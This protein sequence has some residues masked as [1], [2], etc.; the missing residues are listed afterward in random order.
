MNFVIRIDRIPLFWRGK[1]IA[2]IE[3][4][5]QAWAPLTHSMPNQKLLA[6]RLD[7]ILNWKYYRHCSL[8][9]KKV[10]SKQV[11]FGIGEHRTVTKYIREIKEVCNTHAYTHS[12]IIASNV[13]TAEGWRVPVA[14]RKKG[15]QSA[16]KK[17]R[18]LKWPFSSKLVFFIVVSIISARLI[19][20]LSN[21]RLHLICKGSCTLVVV[22]LRAFFFQ[23]A[24]QKKFQG[25]KRNVPSCHFCCPRY[26]FFVT[27]AEDT[28]MSETVVQPS[29]TEVYFAL[30]GFVPNL[31]H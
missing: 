16:L 24:P 29:F 28:W 6:E 3:K 11:F 2:S 25:R 27:V 19:C 17:N 12:L 20:H 21:C 8:F 4:R 26:I 5:R 31:S 13:K 7:G 22:C 15:K 14:F 1:P 9:P 30:Y 23:K 10:M 18:F